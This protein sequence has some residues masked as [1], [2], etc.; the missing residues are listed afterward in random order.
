MTGSANGIRALLIE[1]NPGDARLLREMLREA[2]SRSIGYPTAPEWTRSHAC[3]PPMK[4]Y[5][6]SC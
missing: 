6:L 5:R 4:V 3:I 1:D 2:G